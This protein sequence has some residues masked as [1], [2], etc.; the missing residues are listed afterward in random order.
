M[1]QTGNKLTR[2]GRTD[3]R[4]PTMTDLRTHTRSIRGAYEGPYLEE[5]VL[6][7]L[8]L[9]HCIASFAPRTCKRVM[10]SIGI[11]NLQMELHLSA[12][13]HW[14]SS[15]PIMYF[16]I[17][18]PFFLSCFVW[19]LV[20]IFCRS[21][22]DRKKERRRNQ[23]LALLCCMIKRSMEVCGVSSCN[24]FEVCCWIVCCCRCCN[25]V[26]DEGI[27]CWC[28]SCYSC[29]GAHTDC[30]Q[31]TCSGGGPLTRNPF[32]NLLKWAWSFGFLHVVFQEDAA[33]LQKEL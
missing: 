13:T 25:G 3:G 19:H 18:S 4:T 22:Q 28:C 14:S 11:S 24:F 2:T 16:Q 20:C 23:I 26:W 9:Q 8:V 31:G 6:K 17:F 12:L 32:C 5:E 10:E 1:I 27:D 33:A 29:A 21:L 30:F 7:H 15:P